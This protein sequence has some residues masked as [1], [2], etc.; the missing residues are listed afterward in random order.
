LFP[1]IITK[2]ESTKVSIE[3]GSQGNR[4]GALL[5]VQQYFLEILIYAMLL[6]HN[7]FSILK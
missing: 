6:N 5:L 7:C 4:D 2:A 1:T 3:T